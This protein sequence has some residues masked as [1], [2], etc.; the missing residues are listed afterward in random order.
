ML[1]DA[2]SSWRPVAFA[3]IHSPWFFAIPAA[4]VILAVAIGWRANRGLLMAWRD[5]WPAWDKMPLWNIAEKGPKF[6]DHVLEYYRRTGFRRS[7]KTPLDGTL[8]GF[9]VPLV[10]Q[11]DYGTDII[12]ME[13]RGTPRV[14]V[15]CKNRDSEKVL[16]PTVQATYA[17]SRAW[18]CRRATIHY[19][20]PEPPEPRAER[21]AKKLDVELVSL[22]DYK[23]KV[24]ELAPAGSGIAALFPRSRARIAQAAAVIAAAVLTALPFI[25]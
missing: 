23:T 25:R 7:R 6:E 20:Y 16:V 3:V 22:A 18:G 13:R 21:L 17:G 5:V 9:D 15:Q 1:H 19:T 2:F 14:G 12:V 8:P 10:G 11:G 24:Q 4:L